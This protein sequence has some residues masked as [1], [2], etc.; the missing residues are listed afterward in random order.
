VNDMRRLRRRWKVK[1]ASDPNTT[2]DLFEND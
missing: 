2:G 1:G